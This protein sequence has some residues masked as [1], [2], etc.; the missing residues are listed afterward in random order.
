MS[1]EI[2]SSRLSA[3]IQTQSQDATTG[4][5][6][7]KAL[8]SLFGK[9]ASVSVMSG[10]KTDLEA[11]V[12]KL[13]NESARA[14]FSLLLTSLT[15][16][17]QSMT[18]I[19]KR[20]LEQGVAL[21]E[22]LEEL[23]KD[24]DD[25]SSE[26]AKDKAAMALLQAKIDLLTKQIEQAV[27]DGKEHNELVAEMKRVRE[28]MDEKKRVIS[29][30][31]GKI[32]STENE[33]ASVNGQISA[34]VSSIGENAI[35]SIANELATLSDPEKAE[36]PAEAAKEEEKKAEIDPFAAIRDSL[37]KIDRDIRETIEENRVEMV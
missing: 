17:G 24:L 15:A 16:I 18:D 26:L 4:T 37:D 19:Q 30:T 11:L 28:E 13:R 6:A 29:D 7:S 22:K 3:S 8:A 10:A 27:E 36:R 31:I 2:D 34:L 23:T 25:Y 21:S 35:K 9:G 33:I 20:T 32:Q 14:K 1:I 5:A 12:Q